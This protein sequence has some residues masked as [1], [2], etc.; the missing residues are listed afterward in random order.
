MERSRPGVVQSMAMNFFEHQERARRSTRRLV[1]LFSLAVVGII[2]AL[3]FFFAFLLQDQYG[4][5]F[6]QHG[7]RFAGSLWQPKT[8]AWVMGGTLL[9]SGLACLI[10]IFSLRAG[11]SAVAELVGAV[12][13]NYST[14]HVLE[15]KY[16][17]VVE[18]MAIASG[19]PVPAIYIMGDESNIN[20][21]AAGYSIDDAAV[22]VTRGCIERLDRDELQG[23]VA[24]E[25]SHILNGDMRLNIRLI[26][27]LAGILFLA[28][29]GY[30]LMW[31]ADV[32]SG[33]GS[34]RGK[35]KG[36]GCPLAVVFF[37]VG[38]VLMVIGFIGHLFGSLIKAAVSRQREFLADASAVQFTRN[39]NGIAGALRKIG[40][41]GDGKLKS[42][43]ASEISHMCFTSV[44]GGPFSLKS[45]LI[46][47]GSIAVLYLVI[48]I[49]AADF[50]EGSLWQP[51]TLF[52]VVVIP[53]VCFGLAWLQKLTTL[54]H[55]PLPER[56]SRIEKTPLE[57]IGPGGEAL[58]APLAA[59]VA[60]LSGGGRKSRR[61]PPRR[62][63]TAKRKITAQAADVVA[64]A[65]SV[66]E[67]GIRN[68]IHIVASLPA[69]LA[70]AARHPLS[71]TALV[72]LLILPED[73]KER[74][75]MVRK[76][77]SGI[78]GKGELGELFR[79]EKLMP[80]LDDH[81]RLPLLEMCAPALRLLTKD[82][83]RQF[84]GR[85][86]QIVKLD[87]KVDLREFCYIT[88]IEFCLYGA[89]RLRRKSKKRY[90][91]FN[92]LA[93]DF[94]RV[95]SALADAGHVDPS[96]RSRAFEYA[97]KVFGGKVELKYEAATVAAKELRASI[98][99]LARSSIRM[100]KA[101]L[102]AA[103][104]CVLFDDSIEVREAELLRSLAHAIGVPLPPFLAGAGND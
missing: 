98:G 87:N 46:F 20:A 25:F 31:I 12:E 79:L 55:P 18:E 71:A 89:G 21:F 66:N 33:P 56:I 103:S 77:L 30:V 102:K 67:A 57:A 29:I 51:L 43:K 83:A 4:G 47:V 26:G 50:Y 69:G 74:R 36:G 101:F 24:H 93:P 34:S 64:S 95:L 100:R 38:L 39:P 91:K 45:F 42:P 8:L 75:R 90:R 13:V 16:I 35:D 19:V 44:S 81:A 80:R 73:K 85:I 10:K 2:T 9:T 6:W 94:S 48:A 22:A 82:Q 97:R 27:V 17:N 23:V 52:W 61:R 76:G 84:I 62:R 60:G 54:T 88:M 37:F 96:R 86:E 92:E 72:Y 58:G 15:R 14:T 3:Y 1:I 7:P 28:I 68:A 104:Y 59:G 63:K 40:G 11:G 5:S 41:Y 49:L 99:R 53:M 70:E 78:V 65:G 32:L